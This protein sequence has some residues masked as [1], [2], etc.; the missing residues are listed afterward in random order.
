MEK[1]DDA[2]DRFMRLTKEYKRFAEYFNGIQNRVIEQIEDDEYVSVHTRLMLL[3]K[4][5]HKN[6][7]NL[8]KILNKAANR[9]PSHKE[10]FDALKAQYDSI[11]K[12]LEY[13]LPDGTSQ[14]I[15]E[16]IEDIIYGLY[17]HTDA[18]RIQRVC[19]AE[20]SIRYAVTKEYVKSLEKVVLETYDVLLPCKEDWNPPKTEKTRAH[21]VF[22]GE[23]AGSSHNIKGS[24]YWSN[25][26]G[27]D[28]SA[29]DLLRVFNENSDEDNHILMFCEAFIQKVCK[30]NFS[31][32][33][34]Q[35]YVFPP[36]KQDWGDF[37][38]IH[39]AI[40]GFNNLGFSSKVRYNEQHNMAY[41]L[42]FN[43][44]EEP[45]IVDQPH[46]SND[47]TTITLVKDNEKFGWRIYSIG[48]PMDHY[49][50]V[51]NLRDSVKKVVGI[52]KDMVKRKV[53]KRL[54]KKTSRR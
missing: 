46:I 22:V 10:Q 14:N 27:R 53:I 28:A 7:F 52:S 49:K 54:L 13:I 21:I 42:L 45:F 20:D 19:N 6:D 43:N 44:I 17:L 41:V 18:E 35:W 16:A 11:Y 38:V 50:E 47:V 31:P 8:K 3:R 4:Y 5:G 1:T 2:L 34:L 24:P 51:L 12:G 32:G 30:E 26:Y 29:K 15:G 48:Q 33:E 37:S 40:M 9:F 36:T 25:A 23:T 39:N